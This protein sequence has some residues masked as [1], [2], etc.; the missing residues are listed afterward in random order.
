MRVQII[1]YFGSDGDEL[2]K[3]TRDFQIL[4]EEE[5]P[6]SFEEAMIYLRE[7][8]LDVYEGDG[9]DIRA[10]DGED[11]D[12]ETLACW[13]LPEWF[14]SRHDAQAFLA[15]FIPEIENWLSDLE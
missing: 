13:E 9:I 8:V 6:D 5:D 2:I 3:N 1:T 7:N 14:D 12:T 15:E 10:R 11:I 4:S